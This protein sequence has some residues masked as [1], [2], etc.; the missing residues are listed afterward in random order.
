MNPILQR[1]I[2]SVFNAPED[3]KGGGGGGEPAVKPEEARTFL[4]SFGHGEEALKGMKDDDVVKLHGT[5]SGAIKKHMDTL[6]ES[7]RKAAIEAAKDLKLELPKDSKLSQAD[8]DEIVADARARGLSKE[9]AQ[10]MIEQ[11]GKVISGYESRAIEAFKAERVKWQEAVKADPELGGDK[12]AQT[13]KLSM[14]PVE[15]FMSPALRTMLRETGYGDH[16]EFVRF[17]TSIG[18]AMSE[19]DPAHQQGGGVGDGKKSAE[20]VLYGS[21]SS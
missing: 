4:A 1:A 15:K 6:G 13:Q 18:R 14:L 12:L 17:L 5:V 11:R 2:Y 3:G 20:S 19:D 10:A 7:Q 9:Q 21:G 16:P 8:I